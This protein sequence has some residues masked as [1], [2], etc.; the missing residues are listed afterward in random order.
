MAK[1]LWISSAFPFITESEA[2]LRWA[3][4][5]CAADCFADRCDATSPRFFFSAAAAVDAGT[6]PSVAA[7][8]RARGVEDIHFHVFEPRSLRLSLSYR[9]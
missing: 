4:A 1:G 6:F 7:C 5:V 3:A 8:A 2:G 9:F